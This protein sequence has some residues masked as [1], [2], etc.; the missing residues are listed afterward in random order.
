MDLNPPP[1]FLFSF[2]H[3]KVPS[4]HCDGRVD[5]FMHKWCAAKLCVLLSS[6][7]TR[8]QRAASLLL[9][10]P[11]LIEELAKLQLYLVIPFHIMQVRG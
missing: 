7:L 6:F 10:S 1:F 8:Q 2:F 11:C 4:G 3:Q 5:D 9:M